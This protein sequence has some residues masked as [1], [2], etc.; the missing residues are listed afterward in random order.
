MKESTERLR[1]FAYLDAEKTHFYRPIMRRFLRAKEAFGIHLRPAEIQ[2]GVEQDIALADIEAALDQLCQWGN[3]EKHADTADVATV[4]DFYRPRYLYQLTLEG[5]AVER[6]LE[7]Y[8]DVVER[9]GELQTAALADIRAFLGEIEQLA[10]MVEPDAGK[11]HRTMTALRDRLD[12]LTTNALAVVGSLQRN[13]DLLR[14]GIDEFLVYKEKLIGYIDRFVSELVHATAQIA[15]AVDRIEALDITRILK[16]AGERDVIDVLDPTEAA[17]LDA[18]AAWQSRWQGLRAWFKPGEDGASQS[19]MLRS[20]ARSSIR[21]LLTAAA[22]LN[23]R[24]TARSDR[25]ADLRALALWFTECEDDRDAHRLWRAA[26][27]MAPARHLKIDDATL[28]ELDSHPVPAHTSWL[29]APPID[30]APRLRA[31][32]KHHRPGAPKAIVD[33]SSGKE[34]LAREA[35]AEAEQI[36]AAQQ[37]FATG[38]P[39]R[40]SEIGMLDRVEFS[41]F[42]DLL[43]EALACR[44][45]ENEPVETTSTDGTMIVS[46]LPTLDSRTAVIETSYGAFSGPDHIILVR[47]SFAEEIA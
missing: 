25:V 15:A 45:D 46:L 31:T 30:I 27:G 2:D 36:A 38:R 32:G 4:E 29:D 26:F 19:E 20:R 43:G 16:I 17:K 34:Q 18:I 42:L 47:S 7:T 11:V 41:L 22:A 10:G 37:R 8:Y 1:V 39:I 35:E 5:E 40:L 13:V 44:V 14:A 33:F 12:A 6:A 24:R 28:D 21:A 3:L 9:P 23:D